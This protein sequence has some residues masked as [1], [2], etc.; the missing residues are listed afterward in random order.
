L[1]INN[2]RLRIYHANGGLAIDLGVN[3]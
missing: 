1:L 3:V 2:Q